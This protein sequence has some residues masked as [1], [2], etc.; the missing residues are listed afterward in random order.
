MCALKYSQWHIFVIA[1]KV[2]FF[3]H[4]GTT[5]A[6]IV[7]SVSVADLGHRPCPPSVQSP[8]PGIAPPWSHCPLP[9]H[10]SPSE[11]KRRKKKHAEES[12]QRNLI[13]KRK[14]HNNLKPHCFRRPGAKG[15]K[16][17]KVQVEPGWQWLRLAGGL[18]FS[19]RPASSVVRHSLCLC[20][21]TES[22]LGEEAE[23]EALYDTLPLVPEGKQLT[24]LLAYLCTVI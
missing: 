11:K 14:K 2:T 16:H 13:K 18:Q 4:R 7:S 15:I 22:E 23:M 17:L 21:G 19:S 9:G 1:M 8:D 10:S 6:Q 24:T 3:W 20:P 12:H 5:H